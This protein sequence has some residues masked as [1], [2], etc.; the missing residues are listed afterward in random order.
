MRFTPQNF[1]IP[2]KKNEKEGK[3]KEEKRK[4][5][6]IEEG[7]RLTDVALG[8]SDEWRND[9]FSFSQ[10]NWIKLNVE[11]KDKFFRIFGLRYIASIRRVL[12]VRIK[13]P[14]FTIAISYV[15]FWDLTIILQL[16][17]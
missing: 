15:T 8:E 7:K 13:R 3:R 2:T 12:Y 11:T 4:R 14:D 9:Y 6:R 5:K 16:L 17:L 1:I 10:N